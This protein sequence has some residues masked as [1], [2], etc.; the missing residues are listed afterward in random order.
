MCGCS[1][2]IWCKMSFPPSSSFGTQTTGH[3]GFNAGAGVITPPFLPPTLTFDRF[4]LRGSLTA[5]RIA[6]NRN[7]RGKLF[8]NSNLLF[9][10][11]YS[12]KTFFSTY[13]TLLHSSSPH[14]CRYMIM[15][16]RWAPLVVLGVKNYG[17]FEK[18]DI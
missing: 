12:R 5:Q 3:D 18:H 13:T 10:E 6:K 16:V 1:G 14:A 9:K 15:L 4:E 8:R 2:A 17:F 7:P 11:S